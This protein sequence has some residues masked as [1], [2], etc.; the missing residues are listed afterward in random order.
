MPKTRNLP[1]AP[2]PF[3]FVRLFD[4]LAG[5]DYS[6]RPRIHRCAPPS[7]AA[8]N[9]FFNSAKLITNEIIT[10]RINKRQ[11]TFHELEQT[12]FETG[13]HV[14]LTKEL[15][16]N[17]EILVSVAKASELQGKVYFSDHVDVIAEF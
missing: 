4:A 3:S 12:P 2:D 16:T 8:T 1:R 6:S 13:E 17:Y 10:P 15:L 9:V 7:D 11:V 14:H 5:P